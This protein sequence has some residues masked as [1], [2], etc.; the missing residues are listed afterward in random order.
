MKF[1]IIT[2]CM[3][4]VNVLEKTILSVLSQKDVEMEYIIIDGNSSDGTKAII[5]KYETQLGYWISES[6]NGIFE[7]MNKGIKKASGDVIAF[8]NAGDYYVDNVLSEVQEYFSD[9]SIE[10]VGGSIRFR[11]DCDFSTIIA[12]DYSLSRMPLHM[13]PHQALFAKKSVFDRIGMF[14]TNYRLASDYNWLLKVWMNRINI[15]ILPNIFAD[16]DGSGVSA[17]YPYDLAIEARNSA[18]EMI[19]ST[20]KAACQQIE[21]Y[22]K[23]KLEKV[24]YEQIYE[25]ELETANIDFINS[26]LDDKEY[27]IWGVGR[28]GVRCFKIFKELNICIKGF[29]DNYKYKTIRTIGDYK[30]Y[31]PQEIDRSIK[32]CIATREFERQVEKQIID[33]GYDRAEYILFSDILRKIV[34]YKTGKV[35]SEVGAM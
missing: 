35:Y 9:E 15:C 4:C 18:L 29:V 6:D 19:E 27:Y 22:Y 34:K 3:N 33:L 1:S 25:C 26:F 23:D 17:K 28:A 13:I 8:L 24:F 12:S 7:A 20:N 2:V 16:C 5:E 11:G 32:V 31:A 30:V 10:I 14:D 21:M